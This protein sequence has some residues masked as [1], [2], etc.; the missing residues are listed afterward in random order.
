MSINRAKASLAA[1]VLTIMTLFVAAGL[2][3][4]TVPLSN[5]CAHEY[6]WLEAECGDLYAP[7]EI[8]TDGDASNHGY[9]TTPMLS[10]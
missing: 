7:G 5:H 3:N 9:L 2:A 10:G 1:L 4:S 8:G 6:M